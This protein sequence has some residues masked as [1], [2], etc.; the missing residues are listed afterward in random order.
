MLLNENM[1]FS[2]IFRIIDDPL[3]AFNRIMKEKEKK[4]DE[5]RSP[6]RRRRSKDRH[7]RGNFRPSPYNNRVKD[8]GYHE[9]RGRSRDRDNDRRWSRYGKIN[10]KERDRE[11]DRD[12]DRERDRD[13]DREKNSGYR[14]RRSKSIDRSSR[15]GIK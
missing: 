14:S 13:H 1:N 9:K 5:R 12:R 10:D 15:L 6:D 3:E 7:T 2:I 4:K 8:H 11:R